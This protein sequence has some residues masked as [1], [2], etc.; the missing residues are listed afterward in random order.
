M[1]FSYTTNPGYLDL[2]F[3]MIGAIRWHYRAEN[4]VGYKFPSGFFEDFKRYYVFPLEESL[5]IFYLAIVFTIFRY[6]FEFFFCKPLIARIKFENQND[7][8]KFPESLWK[9]TIYIF[10]WGFCCYLLIFSGRHDYFFN[11]TDIFDDWAIGMHVP[12]EI[13]W[14]YFVQCGFYLHSIYATLYMDM[15]RKDF[16]VMIIHHVVTMTLI[17]VSYATRFYKIGLLVLFVHDITDI[18]LEASKC[19]VYLKN[20]NGKYYAFHEH[21][22]NIGFGC[23]T[24]F[25]YLFRLYWFPLKVLYSAGVVAAHRAAQRGAGMY[26]FFNILLWILLGLNL[27][28]FSFILKFLYKIATGQMKEANDTRDFD[29]DS[30]INEKK[31][32]K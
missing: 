4:M 19:N 31:K 32:T 26:A 20:R 9:A 2:I 3:D 30:Q 11:P 1:N 16:Y 6:A 25:W 8:L 17:I 24:V 29:V 18:F 23:F 13:K 12:T 5:P 28:W 22:A 15:W 10:L 7:A 14:L 27:Y 21:V